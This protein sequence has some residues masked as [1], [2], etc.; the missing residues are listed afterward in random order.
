MSNPSR[1]VVRQT[2]LSWIFSAHRIKRGAIEFAFLTVLYVGYSASRLLASNDFAPARGHALDILTFEKSWRIDAE[3]W[4]NDLASN[5]NRAW[6]IW[7]W[8]GIGKASVGNTIAAIGPAI[9]V[10]IVVIDLI[11]LR[12]IVSRL[13]RSRMF[14]SR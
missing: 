14:E 11:L 5:A 7:N 2:P 9:G 8:L 10:G 12:I 13:D 3:S 1:S 6:R 4:L